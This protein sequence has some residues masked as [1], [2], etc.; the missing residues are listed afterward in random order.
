MDS[1]CSGEVFIANQ[2]KVLPDVEVYFPRQDGTLAADQETERYA[3]EL[4]L[5]GKC[6]KIDSP[7]RVRDRTYGPV[8]PLLIWPS[9]FSLSLEDGEVGIVDATGHVVARIGDE[10]TFSA[11][12]L[13]YQQAIEHGGL[14]EIS[15]ACSGAY[16]AVGEEFTASAPDTP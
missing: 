8:S 4:V 14:E 1:A 15:P 5:D 11:S 9:T 13:S 12:S 10:V 16:W 6:L 3:G 2:I 7:L